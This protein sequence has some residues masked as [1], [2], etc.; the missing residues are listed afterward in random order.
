MLAPFEKELEREFNTVER[1]RMH[2]ELT[3]FAR[4]IAKKPRGFK[5]AMSRS[6][7]RP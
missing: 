3:K 7:S 5:A 2:P 1:L 6:N 4:W